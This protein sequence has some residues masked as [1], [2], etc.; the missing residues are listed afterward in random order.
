[1]NALTQ[2]SFNT[3]NGK[4]PQCSQNFHEIATNDDE[5]DVELHNAIVEKVLKIQMIHW[6]MNGAKSAF[7][8]VVLCLFDEWYCSK[9]CKAISITKQQS[10]IIQLIRE[11]ICT[12]GERDY[13]PCKG[14][15]AD[16]VCYLFEE[17]APCFF[18][19]LI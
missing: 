6:S 11:Y 5:K 3:T 17:T 18:C 15:D 12:G 10:D 4:K 16:C 14:P 13:T 7:G 8:M 9:G 19:S 2:S 1:M